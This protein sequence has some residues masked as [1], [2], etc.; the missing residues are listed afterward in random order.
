MKVCFW[1]LFHL[2]CRE[3]TALPPSCLL[4]MC[5]HSSGPLIAEPKPKG[6]PGSSH[7]NGCLHRSQWPERIIC[8]SQRWAPQFVDTSKTLAPQ[9]AQPACERAEYPCPPSAQPTGVRGPPAAS[10]L[11]LSS[12]SSHGVPQ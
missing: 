1:L 11:Q 5:I 2:H 9:P 8:S 4:N 6:F 12:S 10:F 7:H 3:P